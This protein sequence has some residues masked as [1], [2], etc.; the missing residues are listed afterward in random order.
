MEH[1]YRGRDRVNR[2][3]DAEL[4]GGLAKPRACPR[5]YDGVGHPMRPHATN[6]D[7]MRLLDHEM[8]ANEAATVH[9]HLAECANCRRQFDLLKQTAALH[10]PP[11]VPPHHHARRELAARLAAQQGRRWPAMATIV[12]TAA[13][14]AAIV[15]PLTLLL[16]SPGRVHADGP[17]PDA[18]LTPG[19]T[20]TASREAVCQ[21]PA[22]DEGRRVD[23]A[24]ARQ[25]FERYR[26]SPPRPRTYEV[27]FLIS[28]ALGGSGDLGNLWPVPY[29]G[30][31]WTSR[32]KDALEDHLR[33]QVCSG[34]LDLATAQQDLARDWIAAYRKYFRTREPLAPHA[35]FVK[36][37]PWE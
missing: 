23:A 12:R 27:D 34:Q 33:A 30:G 18:A 37:S 17:R 5:R 8:E 4:G 1:Q 6:A 13:A 3:L 31:G 21:L 19:I 14:L 25:V 7:L 24:L 11:L 22:E 32:V 20:I 16:R 9:A 2:D 36:D 35:A 29:G 15:I 10:L 28:P 26:L